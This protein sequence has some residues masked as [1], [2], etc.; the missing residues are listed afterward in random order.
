M[1]YDADALWDELEIWTFVRGFTTAGTAF[2]LAVFFFTSL[3]TVRARSD[4]ARV[5]FVW[6]LKLVF[7]AQIM[8]V[9]L[10][11]SSSIS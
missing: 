3:C 2:V 5:A 8:Y 7:I 1:D 6:W 11:C 4:P 9:S 10:C